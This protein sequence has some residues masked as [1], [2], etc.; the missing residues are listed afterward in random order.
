MTNF[1]DETLNPRPTG[2]GGRFDAQGTS[3]GDT[4]SNHYT[5]GLFADLKKK[6]VYNRNTRK[7]D[8]KVYRGIATIE[9]TWTIIANVPAYN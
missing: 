5:K 6:T 4:S 2:I 3:T 7:H 9:A 8:T 1:Q